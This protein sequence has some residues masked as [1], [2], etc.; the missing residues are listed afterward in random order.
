MHAH[1]VLDGLSGPGRQLRAL[2]PEVYAAYAQLAK[3]AT[4]EG[5]LTSKTKELIA[6]AIAATRECDGC[7]A[8]HAKNLVR[9]GAT[10]QE[11]AEAMGVV[12][13]MNGGP[14]TVWGARAAEAFDEFSAESAGA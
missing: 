3:A 9:A 6:L 2:I 7:I 5:E 14:G 13:E 1:E 4:A 8:A 11:V 10:R 12:I